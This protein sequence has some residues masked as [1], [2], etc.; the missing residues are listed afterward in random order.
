ME[1][2]NQSLRDD[3][4]FFEE[5]I[6]AVD[7]GGLA[8]RSLQAERLN[9]QELKWQVLLVQAARNAS[10][11]YGHLVL[12]FTGLMNGKSWTA[13]LPAGGQAIKVKQYGR[14]EGVVELPAQVLLKSVTAKV[15]VG[16]VVK[17]VQSIKL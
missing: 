7:G 9:D 11:F 8:I 5:L 4:G 2:T 13:T 1:A 17:V 10:E 3:L 12:D 6:P 16:S 15:M 14:L